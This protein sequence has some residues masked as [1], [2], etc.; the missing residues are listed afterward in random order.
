VTIDQPGQPDVDL[1]TL[2]Q[3]Q[4]LLVDTEFATI[5]DLSVIGTEPIGAPEAGRSHFT[6]TAPATSS[7]GAAL[8]RRR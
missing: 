2:E 1:V 7:D 8:P 3:V 4:R 6:P 5:E